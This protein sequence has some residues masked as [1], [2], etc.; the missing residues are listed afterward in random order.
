MYDHR[1]ARFG[2]GLA[3]TF[4]STIVFSLMDVPTI[5]IGCI[6]AIGSYHTIIEFYVG[7]SFLLPGRRKP[8][9]Q[10]EGWDNQMFD[11]EG[12][13]INTVSNIQTRPSPLMVMVHGWR[14]SSSSVSDRA[15]WFSE[16]GWH[17]VMIELPNH[18]SS[19]EYGHWSAYRSM[20]AVESVATRIERI[21]DPSD[22]TSVSYYGHSMGGFIGLR[23]ASK[24]SLRIATHPLNRMILESPMTMYEPILDEIANGYRV[25]MMLR[26]AYRR[27]LIERFNE[28]IG[29]NGRWSNVEEFNIPL[30]GVPKLPIL[31]VQAVPDERLGMGHFERLVEVYSQPE[32]KGLLTTASLESLTHSGA[33]TNEDRNDAIEHWFANA[34]SL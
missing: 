19:G 21:I 10:S 17:V 20:K 5:L 32:Y 9:F 12:C 29:Q 30:W 26:P 16:R 31:C 1:F 6:V 2:L 13:P 7:I 27:R 18:G 34:G 15:M 3:L 8:S 24:E 23:L 33:R 22:V 14:S 25:P 28:S 11:H 4:L